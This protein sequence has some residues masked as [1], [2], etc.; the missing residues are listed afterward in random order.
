M[1]AQAGLDARE[2]EQ[3]PT[4][5]GAAFWRYTYRNYLGQTDAG[6]AELARVSEQSGSVIVI[7]NYA[8]GLYRRGEYQRAI[9]FLDRR[10]S[11]RRWTHSY[12]VGRGYILAELPDGPRRAR[13]AYQDAMAMTQSGYENF[14][15]ETVLDLLG[16]H[17]EAVAEVRKRRR[18]ADLLPSLGREW[19][20]RLL[21]YECDL[22]PAD[23]LIRAAGGSRL[24][25]CMAHYRIAFHRLGNGDRDGA[26]QH[27]RQCVATN[28][29]MIAPHTWAQAF[30]ARMEK[31]SAW[32]PWIAAK[33]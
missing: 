11:A 20:Q 5:S 33:K 2:L 17:G 24:Q 12:H 1:L 13:E 21:D 15:P 7:M 26:R 28:Y 31:D 30:L 9:E 22:I 4:H 8:L 18:D 19:Q 14:S 29:F 32:P 6:M 25:Q 10:K 3:F 27:F 23:E 16:L